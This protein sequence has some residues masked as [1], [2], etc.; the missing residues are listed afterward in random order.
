MK[1]FTLLVGLVLITGLVSCNKDDD[2][3]TEFEKVNNWIYAN[4]DYYYFWTDELPSKPTTNVDPELFFEELLSDKDRFSFIYEDYQ[5][6]INLLNGITLESGFEFKLY[7]ESEDNENVIMQ[8]TYIKANSPATALGLKRGDIIYKIND[9]QLTTSNY[10]NLLSDMNSTY[11]AEY[12]RY[13][14]ENEVFEEQGS[15]SIA[16]ITYSENPFLLDTI[17]EI[18][19]KKIGYLIY[20]FFSP[21]GSEL[22][23]DNQM[24][25]IFQSFKSAGIQDLILDLRFNSGGSETS[26][27]NLTSLMVKGATT[28]DLVFKKTYNEDV[29]QS[30]LNDDRLGANFLN[31]RFS[32]KT[33]N[34]GNQLSTGTVYIITSSRSAS[35]S[36]VTINSL[37][38]YMEVFIVG[39]T[40]VGKDVGSIT[41]TDED[42]ASNNWAIQPIVVKLVNNNDEDYPNGFNPD[43]VLEDRSLILKP[44]GDIEEPLLA[45]SLAAIGIQASRVDL[46][47]GPQM[48]LIHSSLDD[49]IINGRFILEQ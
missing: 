41:L 38:P 2:T 36:E 25:E 23:Y 24:D 1:N 13:D 12:R 7:L 10:Q 34:I 47:P 8:L 5:E 20:T 30:I 40:T 33:Q 19:G 42:D 37:K 48:R 15:V 31:V 21:G 26:V 11:T 4:M 35:A 14:L 18:E 17:Y 39:D 43:V 3:Q 45:N 22:I 49:K 29:Q 6:L 9:T 44:L 28:S 46:S 16:P 27:K 32:S